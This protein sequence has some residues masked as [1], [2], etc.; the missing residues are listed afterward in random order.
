M[1]PIKLA[2]DAAGAQGVRLGEQKVAEYVA[3]VVVHDE[4]VKQ[5]LDLSAQ[6]DHAASPPGVVVVVIIPALAR[7]RRR[8]SA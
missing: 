5:G 1:L 2:G 6:M 8:R 4:F 3:V 7:W